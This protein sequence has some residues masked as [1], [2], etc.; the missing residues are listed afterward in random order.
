MVLQQAN[1]YSIQPAGEKR[2][3]TTYSL[4]LGDVARRAT[5]TAAKALISEAGWTKEEISATELPQLILDAL[6]EANAKQSIIRGH[7]L[8]GQLSGFG[9][10]SLSPDG[11][12]LFYLLNPNTVA[13]VSTSTRTEKFRL[14]GHTDNIM[15]LGASPDGKLLA[16]S[17]WD[18][19]VKIWDLQ[20]GSLLK[21]L[22]GT[23]EQ[24]WSGSWSPDGK[25]VAVG[26]GDNTVR[27]WD[28]FSGDM[29]HTFGE[30]GD[31][32]SGWVRGL[33]FE[34]SHGR[35][36][37]ASASGGTVRVFDLGSGECTN[38]YQID[39]VASS[40]LDRWIVEEYIEISDVAYA[41]GSGG[42]FAFKPTD[43][44]LVVYDTAQNE[45]WEFIQ[46]KEGSARIYGSG[47]FVF[48]KNGKKVYS[49]D[50]DG[51]VRVWDLV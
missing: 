26:S 49:G 1:H 23:R 20:D 6:R 39:P 14:Q 38:L 42:R 4:N 9:G 10:S 21:T 50:V 13:V 12:N 22:K 44:R 32:F 34:P 45:M 5:A 17:S 35:S 2:T 30:E 19:T 29:V 46:D 43:G 18:C 25:L 28:V 48:G 51:E 24:N 7:S 11:K 33:N 31:M 41:P 40:P 37:V 15:W 27:V 36:L 16:T 8:P 3:E 47:S